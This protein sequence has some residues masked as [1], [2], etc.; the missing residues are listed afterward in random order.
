M[1]GWPTSNRRGRPLTP[2]QRQMMDDS[3]RAT[4]L[5]QLLAD[6]LSIASAEQ[7]LV[8]WERDGE[9]PRP[10]DFWQRGYAWATDHPAELEQLAEGR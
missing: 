3:R 2:V 10:D 4:V 5:R 7:F 6:G 8:T 9:R 1:S